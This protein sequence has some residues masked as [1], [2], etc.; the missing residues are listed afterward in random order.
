M[1][2]KIRT[3]VYQDLT[4]EERAQLGHELVELGHEV[5]LMGGGH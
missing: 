4:D 3:K 2:D 5:E 1:A